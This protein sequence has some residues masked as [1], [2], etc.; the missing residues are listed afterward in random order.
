LNCLLPQKLGVISERME[1]PLKKKLK[2]NNMNLG[3]NY[4]GIIG[5][6]LNKIKFFSDLNL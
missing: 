5:K 6:S 4:I 1:Q 3:D 2:L